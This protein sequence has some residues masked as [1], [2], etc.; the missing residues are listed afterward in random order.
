MHAML[1]ALPQTRLRV[2]SATSNTTAVQ[3][4]PAVNVAGS[5]SAFAIRSSNVIG[6]VRLNT[7]SDWLIRSLT[8]SDVSKARHSAV[9]PGSLTHAP[10]TT[11]ASTTNVI[12]NFMARSRDCDAVSA[13][14]E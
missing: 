13:G 5:F 12:K 10:R 14:S 2:E 9:P 4:E 3:L 6:S 7:F 11:A 1:S 8:E